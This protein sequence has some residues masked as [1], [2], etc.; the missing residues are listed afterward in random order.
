MATPG[1]PR[2]WPL[3]RWNGQLCQG[4]TMHPSW[5]CPPDSPRPWCGQV[6]SV[7]NTFPLSRKTPSWNPP[8]STY[9]PVP[10]VSSS[11]SHND[12]QGMTD[13]MP[14]GTA[15]LGCDL[16]QADG[17][18]SQRLR[19]SVEHSRGRLCHIPE[20][21]QVPIIRTTPFAYPTDSATPGIGSLA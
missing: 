2:S 8:I 15:A 6:L 11:N 9:F 19:P 3:S 17:F 10:S 5:I 4:Q 18:R 20:R 21:S 13:I 12:V 14:C 16:P 7:T 1:A